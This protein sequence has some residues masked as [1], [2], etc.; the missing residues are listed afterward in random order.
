M[1]GKPGLLQVLFKKIWNRGFNSGSSYPLYDPMAAFTES[2]ETVSVKRGTSISTVFSCINVLAQ[3]VA[4]LPYNVRRDVGDMVEIIKNNPVHYLLHT[5]PNDHTSAYNFWYRVVWDMLAYGNAYALIVKGSNSISKEFHLISPIDIELTVVENTVFY[6][7]KKEIFS[8]DDMLHFKMYSF[9]GIKGVSPIVYNA[10]SFG[11]RLKLE[12]YKSNVIG[13]KPPGALMSDANLT[14]LQYEQSM[15]WWKAQTESP[16][17]IP[18]LGGGFK[19]QGFMI[20]PSEGQMIE[21]AKLNREE[22]CGLYRIPPSLIQDYERATFSNAEQQDLVYLKYSLTPILKVIE[23]E[24][25]YKLFNRRSGLYTKFNIKAMLRGDI[26][27]QAE[28]YK[29]LRSFGLSSGDEIRK[30]EDLPPLENDLGKMVFIQ[31]AMIPLDKI[32]DF[33]SNKSADSSDQERQ[34]GFTVQQLK[35]GI[36]KLEIMNGHGK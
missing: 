29:M 31:G 20:P 3:D 25:D 14:D 33:Y 5:R 23:Q 16:G 10:E 2:G 32:S 4:K 35:E 19:F 26:K 34:V 17:K 21:A 28:W 1:M 18:V 22:I 8:Q 15:K 24:C 6:K 36:E 9:D 27:S 7:Y 13:A 11:Y 30:M 12:K